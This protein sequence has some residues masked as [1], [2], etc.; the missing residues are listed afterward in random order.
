MRKIIYILICILC[1]S[2]V[3]ALTQ[4]SNCEEL[5]DMNLDLTEDYELID[6]IDCSDT[7]NWNYNG[8][9]N[10]GFRPIAM[11]SC[12]NL[13]CTNLNFCQWTQQYCD[14]TFG[15][16]VRVCCESEWLYTDSFTGTLNGNNHTISNLNEEYYWNAKIGLF[17]E[18][19]L[20]Y[21]HDLYLNNFNILGRIS[22]GGFAGQ[23]LESNITN[24][25]ISDSTVTGSSSYVG[26]FIGIV[27]PYNNVRIINCSAN[28][29][30]T[31]QTSVGGLIGFTGSSGHNLMIANSFTSG[32]VNTTSSTGGGLVGFG[33]GISIV[34][35]CYSTSD[36]YV[37]VQT[38]GG[39]IGSI[40]SSTPVIN[41]SYASGNVYS[42]LTAGGLIGDIRGTKISN[43]FSTGNVSGTT[44]IGGF[45]GYSTS[46]YITN[47]YWNNHSGNPE[48]PYGDHTFFSLITTIQDN[49]AYFYDV[50]N[51]PMD[52]WDFNNVWSNAY[53]K[54]YYP[55]LLWDEPAR[56]YR[57]I[58]KYKSNRFSIPDDDRVDFKIKKDSFTIEIKD[59][60]LIK[61]MISK[62]TR[63][64]MIES[65]IEE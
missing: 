28:V 40:L 5:Q 50:S 18:L 26:G 45:A 19:D 11:D 9:V 58:Y 42:P 29:N 46:I 65:R 16:G 36:V 55:P 43:S 31:G 35:N 23:I 60:L 13:T 39:L 33:Y 56:P 64:L 53:N 49:E 20:A 41:N 21:I 15:V 54:K 2:S 51:S 48:E 14:D 7:V 38:A 44:N 6:N 27:L 47:C 37:N 61:Q 17:G 59:K 32:I 24:V 4:I 63:L 62:L 22:V 57:L 30:V 1:V 10:L 25:H 8:T 3:F 52:V 12:E 34:N